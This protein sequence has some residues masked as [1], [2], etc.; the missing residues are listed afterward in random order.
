M[1]FII[2]TRLIAAYHL[3]NDLKEVL[4]LC[5]YCPF[6]ADFRAC[7]DHE[8]RRLPVGALDVV[9]S[10]PGVVRFVVNDRIVPSQEQ[11]PDEIEA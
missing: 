1:W 9:P 3:I 5:C 6:L 4:L 2:S 11:T 8:E 10:G 7:G